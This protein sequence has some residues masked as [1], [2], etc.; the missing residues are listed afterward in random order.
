[1]IINIKDINEKSKEKV[2][3]KAYQLS[4][5]QNL[6]YNVCDGYVIT[7]EYFMK[8]CTD[9]KLK[10]T[11]DNIME[12]IFEGN[13]DFMW[14]ELHEI[15]IG[16]SEFSG[17]VIVR[18]SA[19][20]EDGFVKSY[21]GIFESVLN[22]TSYEMMITAIKKVWASYCSRIVKSYDDEF[23]HNL[24]GMAVIIQPM[25]YCEK[26]GVT[27]SR[28]PV[29]KE[30]KVVIE[31]CKGNNHKI[32]N[33]DKKAVTYYGTSK[34]SFHN[35]LRKKE[36]KQINEVSKNLESDFL[37]PC[38]F[39]WGIKENKLWIFQLR[40]ITN[41]YR[42][43]I[44]TDT[45]TSTLNCILLD[46]YAQPAT[47]CYLSLLES[48]Q[49]RIY[50]SFY[51]N[52]L[53][54]EFDEKPLCFLHNRVYW[55][56][57][58]QKKYF[59]ES[60]K[61]ILNKLRFALLVNRSYKDWYSRLP[62][63]DKKVK[64]YYKKMKLTTDYKSLYE[65]FEKVIDNFCDFIG[66]DH[67]RFLGLAQ[68]LYRNLEKKCLSYGMDK[69]QVAQLIGK[70][71]DKNKTVM[72]NNELLVISEMVY[73]NNKLKKIFDTSSPKR[74]LY[75]IQHNEEYKFIAKLLDEFINR[76]G[77][78]GTECDD[79]Y[80][81]HWV[82]EPSK[83]IILIK[84]LISN[85]LLAES[86]NY[87]AEETIKSLKSMSS[88]K[89]KAGDNYKY[90]RIIKLT[91]EYMCLRENQRYYF[92]KSWILM[93]QIL[94]KLSKY[95][96][97][98][99]VIE[100]S[101]DIF[102]MTVEEIKDGILYPNYIVSHE[103]IITRR[104]NY[105]DEKHKK[106]PYIIKGSN[107][108]SLQKTGKYKSYKVMGIS[109]GKARG[110]IKIINSINDLGSVEKY[111]IGVVKTFHPSWTPVLKIVNGL[112]MNYGNMLSHGAV[113]AREYGIPIVVFNDDATEVFQNGEMV[114]ING[115]TGRIKIITNNVME[116]NK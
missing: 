9:N 94:L 20:E 89:I 51:N 36:L 14:E 111:D 99:Q 61:S 62:E 52:I 30:N 71:T 76:H 91:R 4:C 86:N 42:P 7:T 115:T 95:Y 114:E 28:H 19:C 40:P 82:E 16:M 15:F 72:A 3:S 75:E 101:E 96:L 41:S 39:E 46:R 17:A 73:K 109:G 58:Y 63:Y 21:A 87:E 106:P 38:D 59:D 56:V 112:I 103:T 55:N 92:D 31:V 77:H 18:S 35:L 6:G 53:G 113:V 69:K 27:F 8:F 5:L 81:T 85:G 43:D 12:E 105:E 100:K 45:S 108:V 78:R 83:I 84:Q 80:F 25:L 23:G 50:L 44:Y 22:V 68:I 29:T 66:I 11:D 107:N 70:Q 98:K 32:I 90:K 24:F 49:N 110:K 79:L 116:V 102:H 10:I 88:K 74:I 57:E 26:S 47:V 1:M 65:L 2:G 97:H 54:Y 60:K 34:N 104:N 64:L 37:Y 67:F 33:D 93:R 48:W 13:I